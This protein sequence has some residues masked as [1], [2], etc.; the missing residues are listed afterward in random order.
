MK[1]ILTAAATAAVLAMSASAARAS[2]IAADATYGVFDNSQGNRTLSIGQH[3]SIADLDITIEFAKC[4]FIAVGP[5]DT[6]CPNAASG[7]FENE[8]IFSLVSPT[9]KTVQLVSQNKFGQTRP[10]IGRVSMS[11]DD[12]AGSALG[13]QVQ[14]GTFR[15]VGALSDFDGMDMFGD[16]SLFIRDTNNRDPLSYFSSRLEVT[17]A[18][19]NVP[20][21]AS[22]AILGLGLLGIGAARR[23]G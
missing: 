7:A 23:R 16:W 8:I 9:G 13:T 4:G 10:G 1:A 3:G 17:A 5:L 14:A 6:A 12:E 15:P 11:F 2:V 20:E 18:Q 21:P 22:L 19:A